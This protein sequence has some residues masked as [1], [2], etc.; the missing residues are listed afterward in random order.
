MKLE[1]LTQFICDV[2]GSVIEKVEDGYLEWLGGYNEPVYG[3]KI[4]HDDGAS[5]RRQLGK[6][7]YYPNNLSVSSQPLGFVAG[8]DGMSY[9]LTYFEFEDLG[10]VRDPKELVEIIRRLHVPHFEEGRFYIEQ[11]IKDGLWEDNREYMPSDLK[12]VIDEYR[13]E[14]PERGLK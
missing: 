12:R 10:G 8:I 5:P 6:N 4:V 1:P 9:L 13:G 2:C 14:D 11:A 3:F 7:C